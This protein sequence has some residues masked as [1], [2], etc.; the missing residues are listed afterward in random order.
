MATARPFA[1]NT[2]SPITGT[3]QVGSL[4]VGTPTSG[5][6]G[7]PKWWNGPD[8]DLGYIIAIP[9]SGNTQPTPISGVTASVGFYRCSANTDSAFLSLTNYLTGISFTGTSNAR[10]WLINNLGYYTNYPSSAITINDYYSGGVVGYIFKPGEP[11]YVSGQTHG[12]IVSTE[13]YGT[14]VDGGGGTGYTWGCAGNITGLSEIVGSGYTNQQTI[15]NWEIANCPA[16]AI[17]NTNFFFFA[18]GLTNGG[19]TDWFVGSYNEYNTVFSGTGAMNLAN[20]YP[21]PWSDRGQIYASSY[22]IN[23]DIYRVAAFDPDFPTFRPPGSFNN[24]KEGPLS[25]SLNVKPLRYF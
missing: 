13:T 20:Y 15:I 21:G 8:E 2:G 16:S 22:Q 6:T 18:T 14:R 17:T 12:I 5:F 1:Y 25:T 11:R 10:T 9:V 23:N 3:I 24:W 19:Y 7:N 4:A